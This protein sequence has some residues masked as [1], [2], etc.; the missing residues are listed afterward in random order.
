MTYNQTLSFPSHLESLSLLNGSNTDLRVDIPPELKKL[1][2][3]GYLPNDWPQT[4]VDVSLDLSGNL[5][6]EGRCR[7]WKEGGRNVEGKVEGGWRE[8][9]EGGGNGRNE[10]RKVEGRWKEGGRRVDGRWMEGG[11]NGGGGRKEKR[12]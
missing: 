7:R 1:R 6:M 9:V 12:Y 4:L 8:D 2:L 5:R 3:R 10:R 11:G